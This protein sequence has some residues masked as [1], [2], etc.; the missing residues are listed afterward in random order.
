MLATTFSIAFFVYYVTSGYAVLFSIF[1]MFIPVI[2]N[3]L[4]LL[5]DYD[6]KL[7]SIRNYNTVIALFIYMGLVG[8]FQFGL[9]LFLGFSIFE[10]GLS[11]TT[12]ASYQMGAMWITEN[13]FFMMVAALNLFQLYTFCSHVDVYRKFVTTQLIFNK[14]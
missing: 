7:S 6:K 1:G 12:S 5:V 9:L 8:A 4:W 10:G 14:K 2:L 13:L 11:A 3:Y